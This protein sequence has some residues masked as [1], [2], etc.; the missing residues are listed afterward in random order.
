MKEN[1]NRIRLSTDHSID[2]RHLTAQTARKCPCKRGTIRRE[3]INKGGKQSQPSTV[4]VI[5]RINDF[6]RSILSG[7]VQGLILNNFSS[8]FLH[9]SSDHH[10]SAKP[11]RMPFRMRPV[12]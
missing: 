8:E 7:G 10:V 11:K 3:G 12:K 1:S 2:C 4:V 5:S 9:V 6:L